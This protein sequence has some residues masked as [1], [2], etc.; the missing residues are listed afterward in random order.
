MARF[1]TYVDGKLTKSTKVEFERGLKW[2]DRTEADWRRHEG[3]PIVGPGEFDPNNAHKVAREGMAV[4]T[5]ITTGNRR[6]R[7]VVVED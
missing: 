4:L 5:V 6:I 1:R 3:G 2:L 7:F